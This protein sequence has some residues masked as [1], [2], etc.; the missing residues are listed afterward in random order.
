MSIAEEIL[1]GLNFNER[2]FEIYEI[3]NNQ[4]E[5]VEIDPSSTEMAISPHFKNKTKLGLKVRSPNE[6]YLKE[7]LAHELYQVGISTKGIRFNTGID[8]RVNSVELD[9]GKS[10][11]EFSGHSYDIINTVLL[12]FVYVKK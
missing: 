6:H 4:F 1:L 8:G 2:Q 7:R 5:N 11:G 3:L 12:K 9:A 10:K